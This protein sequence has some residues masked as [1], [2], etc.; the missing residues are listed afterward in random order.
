MD[1]RDELEEQVRETDEQRLGMSSE[2]AYRAST[3][4]SLA[5]ER[6]AA[7]LEDE[8]KRQRQSAC[9]PGRWGRQARRE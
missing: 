9:R 3:T 2:P 8:R 7:P 6:R 5:R 1:A 4:R